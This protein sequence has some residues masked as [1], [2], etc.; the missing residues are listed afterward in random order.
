MTSQTLN[1]FIVNNNPSTVV[2][3]H[4]Y[5]DKN[6]KSVFSIFSFNTGKD[7]L[8]ALDRNTNLVILDQYLLG[9]NGDEI[10]KFIRTSFP[11]TRV[12]MF[13]S[14]NEMTSEIDRFIETTKNNFAPRLSTWKK[15]AHPIKR[16]VNYPVEILVNEFKV[17]KFVAIFIVAFVIVGLTSIIIS[18]I[19]K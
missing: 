16:V 9:E 6:F 7:A 8:T 12:I 2:D 13:A 5:I 4:R 19:L 18:N 14:N 17:R 15:I 11:Y 10:R 3:I 1:L